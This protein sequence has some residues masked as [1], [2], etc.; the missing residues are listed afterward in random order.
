[1]EWRRWTKRKQLL[2]DMEEL[3]RNKD[4]THINEPDGRVETK[5]RGTRTGFQSF[6]LLIT[7]FL[8]FHIFHFV[9][10]F[11]FRRFK[12]VASSGCKCKR[13]SW[14]V[15]SSA[16]KGKSI[17]KNVASSAWESASKDPRPQHQVCASAREDPTQDEVCKCKCDIAS[18]ACASAK[19]KSWN[20]GS[21]A[22]V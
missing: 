20:P 7:S 10:C 19:K 2:N 17:S 12:C 18:S 6:I 21:S 5:G 1:M 9:S 14:N 13:R 15:V 22:Q 16:R 4:V 11:G 3:Q 8:V